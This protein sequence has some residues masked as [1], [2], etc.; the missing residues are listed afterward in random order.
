MKSVYILPALTAALALTASIVTWFSY[1]GVIT[2]VIHN[3]ADDL[4][5]LHVDSIISFL[6][7][8]LGEVEN[9]VDQLFNLVQYSNATDYNDYFRTYIVPIATA[10]SL[11]V[12]SRG[13]NG[14]IVST[15][16]WAIDGWDCGLS[17]EIQLTEKMNGIPTVDYYFA[18]LS[19]PD[20]VI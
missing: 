1:Y 17:T 7:F 5:R 2:P 16:F 4:T 8:N 20:S 11:H 12:T 15:S 14:Y 9:E 13:I 6:H 18:N 3:I 19:Q 10:A